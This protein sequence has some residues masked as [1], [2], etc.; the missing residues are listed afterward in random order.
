MTESHRSNPSSAAKFCAGGA[1]DV[2]RKR[3]HNEDTI[4]SRVDLGLFVVADGMG[5]HCAGDYASSL[6]ASSM[7]QFFEATENNWDWDQPHPDFPDLEP[8]AAR[9][10]VAIRRAN[11]NVYDASVEDAARKGMGTTVVAL[12]LTS[13][14]M[15]HIAHVGDSRCYRV[16]VGDIEQVTQDHSFI[17]NVRWAQPSI[18]DEVIASIPKNIITRALGTKGAIEIDVRSE[19]TLPGDAYLICSDGLSGMVS[20]AQ[21]QSVV[22][23]IEDPMAACKEL[24][25][26]ANRG[27]GKD[28]ISV[29]IVRIDD[30]GDTLSNSLVSIH[31]VEDSPL[32]FDEDLG[33]WVCCECGHEHVDGTSFCVEC[34]MAFLPNQ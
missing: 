8:G 21:I 33:K 25:A 22:E 18:D 2:G 10:A 1:T 29:V 32:R 14:G 28:N 17:N 9:L 19:M 23:C 26:L 20:T 5:G 24:I 30:R 34:G 15:I 27:G 7:E 11:D 4:L 16:G 31:G 13:D 3:K 6:T 12:H